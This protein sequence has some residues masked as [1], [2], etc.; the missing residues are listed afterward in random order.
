MRK[1]EITL[2]D[3][4]AQKLEAVASKLGLELGDFLAR[5]IQEYTYQYVTTT[6]GEWMPLDQWN[7]LVGGEG[8]PLCTEIASTKIADE[9]G[10]T[11]ADLNMG[12]LRLGARQFALGYCVLICKKHVREPYELNIEERSIFFEDLM[13]AAQAIDKVF[14]PL[15]M[16]LEILGN[17]IP[18]L[19]CHIIPRYFGDPSPNG[20]LHPHENVPLL[21]PQEYEERAKLIQAALKVQ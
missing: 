1:V 9:Y 8:C 7:A 14:N 3:E 18:H 11:V 2:N 13:H 21:T 5:G 20:P 19:H 12:R 17:T 16:N 15:K 10:Y 4:V 6:S